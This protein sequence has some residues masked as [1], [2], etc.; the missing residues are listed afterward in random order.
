MITLLKTILWLL[1]CLSQAGPWRLAQRCAPLWMLLSPDKRH[2]AKANLAACYP[3]L[4]S[5]TR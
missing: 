3:A 5:V 4:D 1:S 2:V